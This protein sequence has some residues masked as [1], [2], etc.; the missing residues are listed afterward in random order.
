MAFRIDGLD[1]HRVHPGPSRVPAA[2]VCVTVDGPLQLSTTIAA[3]AKSGTAA[4]PSASTSALPGQ[5]R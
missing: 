1:R 5:G 2:G 3:L 4:F